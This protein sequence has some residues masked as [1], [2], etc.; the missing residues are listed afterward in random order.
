MLAVGTKEGPG[1]ESYV[2]RRS[3]WSWWLAEHAQEWE[4]GGAGI[5]SMVHTCLN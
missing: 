5:L 3:D 4:G 2:C 1:P